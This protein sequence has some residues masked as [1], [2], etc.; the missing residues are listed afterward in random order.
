MT[1]SSLSSIVKLSLV[2]WLSQTLI[3]WTPESGLRLPAGVL[4]SGYTPGEGTTVRWK[5]VRQRVKSSTNEEGWG[6]CQR[7]VTSSK[8][9]PQHAQHSTCSCLEAETSSLA[10]PTVLP[11]PMRRGGTSLLKTTGTLQWCASTRIPALH[12]KFRRQRSL[13][14]V[15][16]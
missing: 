5:R 8:T 13:C 6:R 9:S 7:L 4:E 10:S 1:S 16:W 11:D 3:I 12:R 15:S 14:T 2:L